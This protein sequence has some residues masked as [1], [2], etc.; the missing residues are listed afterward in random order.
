MAQSLDMDTFPEAGELT[1]RLNHNHN[2]ELDEQEQLFATS[3]QKP[4]AFLQLADTQ[5]F[6][7]QRLKDTYCE[8]IRAATTLQSQL[9]TEREKYNNVSGLYE[10]VGQDG[11]KLSDEA[12]KEAKARVQ[13]Y[14]D[15][16]DIERV[17]NMQSST[18]SAL[19]KALKTQDIPYRVVNRML[20]VQKHDFSDFHACGWFHGATALNQ[21]INGWSKCMRACDEMIDILWDKSLTLSIQH[22]SKRRRTE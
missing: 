2:A 9:P 22:P 8:M 4:T 21:A 11:N 10:W 20:L 13:E 12:V 16:V 1:A 5:E 19:N 17:F 3:R 6:L 7:I 14:Q 15:A 18:R